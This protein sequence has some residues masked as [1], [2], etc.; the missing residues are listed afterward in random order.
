M[1]LWFICLVPLGTECRDGLLLSTM[2][3]EVVCHSASCASLVISSSVNNIFRDGVVSF[4]PVCVD[5]LFLV[6]SCLV[7]RP[8]F[9]TG[10]L[11]LSLID[12]P[13]SAVYLVGG[14]ELLFVGAWSSVFLLIDVPRIRPF[15]VLGVCLPH[16]S[17]AQSWHF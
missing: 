7:L 4:V 3:P 9:R 14:L 10:Y 13:L 2:F 5:D 11:R 6:G 8:R 1:A 16:D 15:H 17:R 12:G